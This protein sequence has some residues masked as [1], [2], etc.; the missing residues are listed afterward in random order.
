MWHYDRETAEAVAQHHKNLPGHQC[1]S[2]P[3]LT[4]LDDGDGWTFR[5]KAAFLDSMPAAYG[6][7]VGGAKVGHAAGPIVYRSKIDE[8]VAQTG[9]DTFR[10][11]RPTKA[12]NIAAVHPGGGEFRATNR[13]GSLKMPSVQGQAQSIAF[14][15]V[16]DLKADGRS[17]ELS[18][19]ATS[20]LEVFYEV[21]YG[22][23]E[24]KGDQ[25]RISERP[26]DARL[27]IEC[28]I[29]AWQIGRRTTP[30]VAAAAP[31]SQV[32]RVVRP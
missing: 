31:V 32:F 21:D 7:S 2:N 14:P 1:M 19:R 22:P 8:P 25:V 3:E 5:A 26:H 18:A 11:L 13:W 30:A 15:P 12:A 9:L 20:G 10:L 16:A 29:T 27:P 23:V 24:I 6:G 4:W 17:C 28:R